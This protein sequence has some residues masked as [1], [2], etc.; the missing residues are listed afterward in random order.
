M[1]NQAK[2]LSLL[3]ITPILAFVVYL[4]TVSLLEELIY[5]RLLFDLSKIAVLNNV[6]TSLAFA[7]IHQ[8]DSLVGIM[9]YF[10]LGIVL[11]AVSQHQ[12][13]Q[14]SILIHIFWNLLVLVGQTWT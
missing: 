7:L 6:L 3:K 5:H 8:S 9:T 14:A 10:S 11:G 4:I 2:L 12:G 1:T 13:L